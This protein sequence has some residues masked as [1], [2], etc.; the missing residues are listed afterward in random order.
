MLPLMFSPFS[1]VSFQLAFQDD[2]GP[3]L[4]RSCD[5][6]EAFDEGVELAIRRSEDEQWVPLKFYTLSRLISM[7]RELRIDIGRYD[8]DNSVLSLQGYNVS[9]VAGDTSVMSVTVNICDERFFKEGIQFRWLQTVIR[10][11]RPVRD[12]WFIDNVTITVHGR[13]NPRI[14]FFDN[15][16]DRTSIK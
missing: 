13:Q 14:A 8:Q 1:D 7:E 12:T 9:V 2:V 10:D 4:N 15:F 3:G 16:S 6:L 11:L 5:I